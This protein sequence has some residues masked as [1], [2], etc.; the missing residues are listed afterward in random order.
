MAPIPSNPTANVAVKMAIMSKESTPTHASP[1]KNWPGTRQPALQR[2][3][4]ESKQVQAVRGNYRTS[5]Q[6]PV[7]GVH[8]DPLYAPRMV[9]TLINPLLK[10]T[11]FWVGHGECKAI[12][13]EFKLLPS[14]RAIQWVQTS[15]GA[16]VSGGTI[17][18]SQIERVSTKEDASDCFVMP[19]HDR[20]TLHSITMYICPTHTHGESVGRAGLVTLSLGTFDDDSRLRWVTG[21]AYLIS[22]LQDD[23]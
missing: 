3:M 23:V 20:S 10:G 12:E 22:I 19:D 13:C 16:S 9:S 18:L 2:A 4:A 21:L 8:L 11:T 15:T 6:L 1:S 14:L 5:R 17:Q 7:M